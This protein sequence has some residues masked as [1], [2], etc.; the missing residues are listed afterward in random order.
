MAIQMTRAEYQAKYGAPPP[1][2]SD[3]N[4]HSIGTT[5]VKKPQSLLKKTS[6]VLNTVFGGGKIGDVIGTQIAKRSSAGKLLSQQ[7]KEG[8]AP[9][10]SL[11]ET[12]KNP[13]GKEIVGDVLGVASTF[14]PAGKVAK[15]ATS[16]LRSVG[17]K[18]GVNALGKLGAG[19]AT[20]A[21]FD[22]SNSLIQNESGADIV[23]PGLGTALGSVAPVA[24]IA[25]N[26]SVR[27]GA[28]QAPRIVNS[29]IKPLSKDFSYGKNPGRA[30]AEE[31]IVANNFDD[32][33]QGINEARSKVGERIGQIGESLSREPILRISQTLNGLDEAMRS[34]AK[35]NNPTLLQRIKNVKDAILYK[36]EPSLDEVGNISIKKV[37]ERK[38]DGLTFSEAR[39]V[40]REIGDMTQFTGNPSDDKLV[41]S[42]LKSIYG[43]IKQETLSAARKINPSVAKEFEKL[44]EKYADLTSAEVAAKY[45]DKIV[46][47]SNMVGLSPAISGLGSAMIATIASGGAAI[48]AILAGAS[49]VALDK[50][51]STPAFKTRLAAVLSTKTQKEV[52]E[53]VQ[54]LPMLSR[55]FTNK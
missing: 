26:F 31:K 17:M 13:T 32:L 49:G 12:F 16:A 39:D 10:G 9:K 4:Q 47:R 36:L 21:A 11:D 8:M 29:L 54:K 6:N 5:Q 15:G 53:L 45:R 7:E 38:L 1:V 19:L 27:F 24:N 22:V 34:A 40:L 52:N 35:Q 46:E 20:G 51:A 48:P 2:S 41:N 42:A 50:L 43:S 23:K 14:I 3:D 55:F 37:S 25:K 28:E 44:T 33:I 18:K 30:I